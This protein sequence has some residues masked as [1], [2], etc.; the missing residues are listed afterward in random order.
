[1]IDLETVVIEPPCMHL[2]AP[3]QVHQLSRSR[4]TRGI[5]LMFTEEGG[6]TA[7]QHADLNDLFHVATAPAFALSSAQFVEASELVSAIERELTSP[8]GPMDRA[9]Q[10]YLGILLLK[11]AAW[12]RAALPPDTPALGA[13]DP[14]R[15][16]LR[17]VEREYLEHRQVGHYA[18]TLA[19]SAD[20]LSDL[21]RK[22]LGRSASDVIQ[23]RLLL[24]AKRLLLHADLSVKEV[25]HAL[26][27]EDPAYFNRVFKKA[28]GLTPVE[29]RTHI[30]EKYQR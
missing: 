30:R 10:G 12:R 4:D 2:V 23:D 5:V 16:F 15:R 6:S 17:M 7:D 8:A 19:I 24:E 20:H 9:V 1:M 14:V 26:H 21:V 25:S 29:Y 13:A 22:R 27:M 18:S 28:T 11:C 3:G